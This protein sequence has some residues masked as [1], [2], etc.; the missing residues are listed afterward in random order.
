[1]R[2]MAIQSYGGP[3]VLESMDL[4]RPQIAPDQVL[5]KL[6]AA[7]INPVDFKIRKGLLADRLPNRFPIILGWDGAGE[8]VEVG[9]EIQEFQKGDAIFTYARKGE[10][11]EGTYAEFIALNREHVAKKP[12]NLSFIEAAVVPLAALTAFQ[13]LFESLKLQPG[14]NLLIPGAAGGVGSYAV[15]L[16]VGAGARVYATASA[17]KH[18]HLLNWGVQGVWDYHEPAYEAAMREAVPEGFDAVFDTVGGATQLALSAFLKPGGRLTSIL[19]LQDGVQ[20]NK[21]IQT[22]Y[23]FVRPDADQLGQIA[24]LIEEKKLTLPPLTVLPLTQAAEG[25]RR[26]EAGEVH[27]KLAL[28][29]S[30]S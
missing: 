11:H 13:A 5:V 28:E 22:G 23:V 15:Q 12:G 20:T 30:P 17:A 8:V 4:P 7:G 21:N 6:H 16:A 27:G 19:A 25:H 26:L 9:N 3:E 29:I 14:E 2:C 24:A 18:Q 1:M 10:I